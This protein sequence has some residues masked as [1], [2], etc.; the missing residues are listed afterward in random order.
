MLMNNKMMQQL[1][2]H[3]CVRVCKLQYQI[4][5]RVYDGIIDIYIHLHTNQ[6]HVEVPMTGVFNW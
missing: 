2:V 3:K 6:V 5:S 1:C 4:S